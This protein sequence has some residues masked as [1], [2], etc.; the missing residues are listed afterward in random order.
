MQFLNLFLQANWEHQDCQYNDPEFILDKIPTPPCFNCFKAQRVKKD[1]LHNIRENDK[2]Y[3]AKSERIE[4]QYPCNH[5]DTR[6]RVK[7]VADFENAFWLALDKI[8]CI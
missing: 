3:H 7:H 5:K 2:V 1:T 6:T 4:C 8:F